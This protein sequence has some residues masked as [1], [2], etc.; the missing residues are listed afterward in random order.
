MQ[1][2]PSDGLHYIERSHGWCLAT[3][4]QRSL[5]VLHSLYELCHHPTVVHWLS[6]VAAAALEVRTSISGG[7]MEEG[8]PPPRWWE[9]RAA[10]VRPRIETRFLRRWWWWWLVWPALRFVIGRR[11]T[12]GSV[13]N[14]VSRV[15]TS[16][17]HLLLRVTATTRIVQSKWFLCPHSVRS[18]SVSS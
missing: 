6:G 3:G 15:L 10:G 11:L 8:P 18:V 14:R 4:S 7:R 17:V 12:L 1:G 9:G 5:T 16:A 13:I 2:P